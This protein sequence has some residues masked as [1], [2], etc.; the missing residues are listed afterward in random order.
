MKKL[1]FLVVLISLPIALG[2]YL[3]NKVGDVRPSLLPAKVLESAS[4]D[5]QKTGELSL[6]LKVASGFKVGVFATGLGRARDLEFSNE[7]VLLV[8]DLNGRILALPDEDRDGTSDSIKVVLSNLDNPHGIAFNKGKLY[9]AEETKVSRYNLDPQ[10]LEA[11]KEKDVLSL[12]K[13]VGHFT[14]S[15][16][17][18]GEKMYISIGS[19]CNVCIEKDPFYASV[20]VSDLEGRSPKVYSKGL[21]NAV[22]LTKFEDKIY[23]TEMGRDFLGDNLPPDEVNI[24]E[25]GGDY[26]WPNCY[27]DRVVD[28][29]FNSALNEPSCAST[30][31]PFYNIPAHSAP[32][33]LTFIKSAQFPNDFQGDLLVSYH[34]SWNRSV[35]D[36]YKVSRI[37]IKDGQATGEEDFLTGFID[38]SQAIARPVDLIFDQDGSLYI[39]D[40]KSGYIFKVVKE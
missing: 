23:V 29:N 36:G 34:G 14:R 19:T 17:I 10:K 27:G 7:G 24:L 35:P 26:G 25:D 40:D 6:P 1:L 31:T 39:S 3:L 28:K 37:K 15:L 22:F 21:R 30:I 18:D 2:Y 20:I 33:G 11:I 9:V 13:G 5:P 4:A 8:S 32:L 38:G 16:L 12:P